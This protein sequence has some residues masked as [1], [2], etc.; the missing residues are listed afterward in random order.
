MNIHKWL[1]C[2]KVVHAKANRHINNWMDSQ[3]ESIQTLN[4][5]R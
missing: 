5:T 4:L 1:D 3:T 2:V